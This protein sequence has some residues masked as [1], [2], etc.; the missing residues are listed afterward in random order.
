MNTDVIEVPVEPVF[1]E[2]DDAVR[3]VA[4]DGRDDLFVELGHVGPA[5]VAV[6]MIADEHVGDAERPRGF[7]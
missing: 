3:T 1:G 6:G 5:Q 2:G 4:S 7:E